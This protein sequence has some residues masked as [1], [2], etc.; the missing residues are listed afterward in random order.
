LHSQ[1][2]WIEAAFIIHHFL[3]SNHVIFE[4][5]DLIGKPIRKTAVYSAKSALVAA[6]P[7][8][9]FSNGNFVIALAVETKPEFRAGKPEE[10]F[11]GTYN[12]SDWDISPK[13]GRFLMLKPSAAADPEVSAS[14]RISVVTNWF[15][16]LKARA[17]AQ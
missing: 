6:E 17:P 8:V 3:M 4:P 16:E 15:E 7:G 13:N 14:S 1:Y 11:R 10:L 5:L 12:V 9:V 2:R